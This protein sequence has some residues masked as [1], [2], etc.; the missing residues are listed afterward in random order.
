M[1]EIGRLLYKMINARISVDAVNEDRA[2]GRTPLTK[3]FAGEGSVEH[4]TENECARTSSANGLFLQQITLLLCML[5]EQLWLGRAAGGSL[6]RER[7]Q[8]KDNMYI[9]LAL[10]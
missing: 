8:E 7:R 2:D 4:H 9:H 1:N 10:D 6:G 5:C 3:S